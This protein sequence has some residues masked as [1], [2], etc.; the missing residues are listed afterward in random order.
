MFIVTTYYPDK[1]STD[2]SFGTLREALD[3]YAMALDQIRAENAPEE[4]SGF[5]VEL[6][7]VLMSSDFS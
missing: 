3:S 2:E 5:T 6:S 4:R 7:Q 1:G